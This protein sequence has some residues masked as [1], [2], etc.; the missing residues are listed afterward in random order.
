MHYGGAMFFVMHCALWATACFSYAILETQPIAKL[1]V[2]WFANEVQ[3][4]KHSQ[5]IHI[6]QNS[7][8]NKTKLTR[9]AA[10]CGRIKVYPSGR[11]VA[12]PQLTAQSKCVTDIVLN[13]AEIIDISYKKFTGGVSWVYVPAIHT[14]EHKQ[15][16]LLV[17]A[18][19]SDLSSLKTKTI[20]AACV[21]SL[22]A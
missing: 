20:E 18:L 5:H 15:G 9:L 21:D 4:W 10:V 3:F 13:A 22:F 1:Y 8:K 2:A 14:S 6:Q 7:N 19:V 17:L 16:P 11:S 12:P